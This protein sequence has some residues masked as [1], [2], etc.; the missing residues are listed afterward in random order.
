MKLQVK[1]KN[2]AVECTTGEHLE[3][4]MFVSALREKKS[5][6]GFLKNG[7][8]ETHTLRRRHAAF[9]SEMKRRGYR[10]RTPLP[11]FPRIRLGLIDTME[12]LKI[13]AA[14]CK[15]CK[16]LQKF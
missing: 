4:H 1:E 5:L 8:L 14:R 12:N 6:N 3:L 13:L 16:K 10:H 11:S 7:L 15:E 9:V 2:E